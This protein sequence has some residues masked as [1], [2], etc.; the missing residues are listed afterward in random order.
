MQDQVPTTPEI[1][2]DPNAATAVVDPNAN[3]AAATDPTTLLPGDAGQSLDVSSSLLP[4]M[5]RLDL[6]M[7]NTDS[8]ALSKMGFSHLLD[9][10]DM[11]GMVA[12]VVLAV[13][14]VL[15]WFYILYNLLRLVSVRHAPTH[16]GDV[17]HHIAA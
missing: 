16:D 8:L 11:V 2:A 5:D 6:M 3:A 13:M 17:L 1:A 14:S 15:V 12:G 10:A 7:G 9:N 4:G